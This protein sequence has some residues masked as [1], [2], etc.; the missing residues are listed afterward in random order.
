MINLNDC[1]N[2]NIYN[3]KKKS[4]KQYNWLVNNNIIEY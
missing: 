1:G 2:D 3:L 4:H